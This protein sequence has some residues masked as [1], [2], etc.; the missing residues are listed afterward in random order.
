MCF[1]FKVCGLNLRPEIAR[2]KESK[3]NN[4]IFCC[5]CCW[6]WW[7]RIYKSWRKMTWCKSN[8]HISS[9]FDVYR[10][11]FH[12]NVCVCMYKLMEWRKKANGLK[13]EHLFSAD[14]KFNL[15]MDV[16]TYYVLL[17]FSLQ[18]NQVRVIEE[19]RATVFFLSLI[20]FHTY[21]YKIYSSSEQRCAVWIET[22]RSSIYYCCC[23]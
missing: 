21:V 3:I 18:K 2:G 17:C 6:M 1:T 12:D 8:S 9:I 14:I 16:H 5:C 19:K 4:N 13:F 10:K 23:C 22:N 20:F 7:W 15:S 11:H